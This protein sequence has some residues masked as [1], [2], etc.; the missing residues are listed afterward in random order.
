MTQKK[1]AFDTISEFID[2]NGAPESANLASVDIGANSFFELGL[3]G[4]TSTDIDQDEPVVISNDL[5]GDLNLDDLKES[6]PKSKVEKKTKSDSSVTQD[7]DDEDEDEEEVIDLANVLEKD[8]SYDDYSEFSIMA[9]RQVKNGK[10]NLEESEIPKDLDAVTLMEMY[11]AQEKA[12]V[13]KTKEETLAQ[14]GE[15]ANYIKYLMD[16]G[17]PGVVQDSLNLEALTSLDISDEDNQK[18]VLRAFFELKQME[19]D[20]IDDTIEAILDKGKGPSKAQEAIDQINRYKESILE[21]KNKELEE[22]KK[23]QK[24][25]YDDYVNSFTATVRTGNIGG[26]K[27]DKQKQ[28]QLIDAMFKPTETIEIT[29]PQTGEKKKTKV[30][31]SSLLFKEMNSDPSKLAAMTLWLLHGGDFQGLKQE[32]K[33]EKD[34][35]LRELL[36]GRKTKTVINTRQNNGSNA[37]EVLAQNALERERQTM[38]YP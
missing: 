5:I 14:A 19:D 12:T 11:D 35:S 18:T 31:K 23:A 1:N 29:N 32:I 6:K 2:K 33:V 37:F 8:N 9:L 3:P 28:D 30:T 17:D 21:V 16:G 13:E 27:I 36:K 22:S 15:Y 7:S 25:Q 26:V 34:D 4:V 24:K 20:V 38:F 10:W